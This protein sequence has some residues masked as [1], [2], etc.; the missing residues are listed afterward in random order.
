MA[1]QPQAPAEATSPWVQRV[2]GEPEP[3]APM[4]A[5]IGVGHDSGL[6]SRGVKTEPED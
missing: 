3:Q 6:L 1:A 4:V 2:S 5:P